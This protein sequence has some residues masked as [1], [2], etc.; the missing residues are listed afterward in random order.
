MPKKA[1]SSLGWPTTPHGSGL[2]QLST[3]A[4]A[5]TATIPRM[6]LMESAS[7][8]PSTFNPKS[9]ITAAMA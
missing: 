3:D 4:T 6:T 2:R 8:T 5:S 9:T 7:L 1:S